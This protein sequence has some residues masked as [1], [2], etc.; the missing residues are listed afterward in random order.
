MVSEKPQEF[1]A[2]QKV[3]ALQEQRPRSGTPAQGCRL[4]GHPP[5]GP[6]PALGLWDQGLREDGAWLCMRDDVHGGLEMAL[7]IGWDLCPFLQRRVPSGHF[8]LLQ[9][10]TLRRG[11]DD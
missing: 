8:Q 1:E 3:P 6:T 5:G 7:K 9:T 2:Q 11:S 4:A 10:W